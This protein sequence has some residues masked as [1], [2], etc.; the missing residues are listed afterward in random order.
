MTLLKSIENMTLVDVPLN[1]IL[2][3][4]PAIQDT[5]SQTADIMYASAPDDFSEQTLRC[6]LVLHPIHVIKQDSHFCVIAGFRSFELARLRLQDESL[7]PCL[8]HASIGKD[9]LPQIAMI[10]IAGSPIM[11]S[12]GPKFVQ[13]LQNLVQA[14][15]DPLVKLFPRLQS[16]RRIRGSKKPTH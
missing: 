2:G 9:E 3:I 8:L 11:H 1:E 10:D 5:V 13:Q 15:S 16:I 12:L 4:H 7:V 6:L 14:F